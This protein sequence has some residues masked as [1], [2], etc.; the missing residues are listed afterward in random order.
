[1]WWRPRST[2]RTRWRTCSG[3]ASNPGRLPSAWT[4]PNSCSAS[5]ASAW[6]AGS[7]PCWRPRG[8]SP[9]CGSAPPGC[10]TGGPM[11][12]TYFSAVAALGRVGPEP[13]GVTRVLDLLERELDGDRLLADLERAK[14]SRLARHALAGA[15]PRGGHPGR[16]LL[17]RLVGLD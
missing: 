1:H 3:P 10:W 11:P 8:T 15:D 2:G 14:V 7:T 12:D 13:A 16:A 17:D 6:I 5:T 4:T 9:R